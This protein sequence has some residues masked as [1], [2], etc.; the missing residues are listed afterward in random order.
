GGIGAIENFL[1]SSSPLVDH[2]IA[3]D[4]YWLVRPFWSEDGGANGVHSCSG[5]NALF[6]LLVGICFLAC[7]QARANPHGVSAQSE[8]R[9]YSPSHRLLCFRDG[10]NLH[11]GLCSTMM[12]TG[13]ESLGGIIPEEANDRHLILKTDIY[14]RFGG[15][16]GDEVDPE[17]SLCH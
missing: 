5:H 7:N 14:V 9:L 12:Q 4:A 16:L 8:C 10:P 3:H 1:L 11:P 13:D 2:A 17:R 6:I 15:E